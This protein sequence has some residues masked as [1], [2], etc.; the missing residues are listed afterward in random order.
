MDIQIIETSDTQIESAVETAETPKTLAAFRVNRKAFLAELTAVARAVQKSN[1]PILANVLIQATDGNVRLTCTDLEL[2]LIADCEADVTFGGNVTVPA[3]RLVDAVKR[4]PGDTVSIAA[5]ADHSVILTTG[6]IKNTIP[7]MDA[8]SFPELPT[9]TA[10]T[11]FIPAEKLHSAIKSTDYAISKEESRFTLNGALMVLKDGTCTMVATDGHRLAYTCFALPALPPPV[12][13]L[14][15]TRS[16]QELSRLTDKSTADVRFSYD[17]NHVFFGLGN[18]IL[19]SRKLTGNFP[20]YERVMPK[21]F[22]HTAI[23]SKVDLK[24]AVERALPFADDRSRALRFRLLPGELTVHVSSVENG[25]Y[26]EAIGSSYDGGFN[27]VRTE[28]ESGEYEYETVFSN[29]LEIAFKGDYI[30]DIIAATADAD[31]VLA[32][33][34]P[35]SAGEFRA[36]NSSESRHVVMPMRID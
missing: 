16:L 10:I 12:K 36:L 15:P 18:R 11:A 22:G 14:I 19:V 2:G 26:S 30:L 7:G 6:R 25:S 1:I 9:E 33:Q 4:L 8:E 34:D 17:D 27:T 21:D 28:T 20:D 23:M 29:D 5:T 13:A 24:S 35:K 3:K 31:I 32:I